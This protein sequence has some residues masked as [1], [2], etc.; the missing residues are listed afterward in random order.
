MSI[1]FKHDEQKLSVACGAGHPEVSSIDAAENIVLEEA[2][3]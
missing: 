3:G 2:Q 1:K